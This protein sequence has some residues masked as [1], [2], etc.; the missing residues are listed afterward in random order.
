MSEGQ[1]RR[2]EVKVCTK[3]GQS[4]FRFYASHRQ[5]I[6][7]SYRTPTSFGMGATSAY[8]ESHPEIKEE[9]KYE[10]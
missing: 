4:A 3:C 5:C 6:C 9:I 2:Q 7:C 1:P 10:K 8:A